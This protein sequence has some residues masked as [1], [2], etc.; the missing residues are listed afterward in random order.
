MGP[1]PNLKERKTEV[2]LMVRKSVIKGKRPG[3]RI[4]SVKNHTSLCSWS[5]ISKEDG[6]LM[7]GFEIDTGKPIGAQDPPLCRS[8]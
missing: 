8:A 1:E 3:N 4:P 7:V 6:W 5:V 2:G